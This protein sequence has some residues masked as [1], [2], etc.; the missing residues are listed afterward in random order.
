MIH[1]L[2]TSDEDRGGEATTCPLALVGR[3]KRL[4][5]GSRPGFFGS[6]SSRRFSPRFFSLGQDSAGC[7]FP[8]LSFLY[9]CLLERGGGAFLSE[10]LGQPGIFFFFSP[11][12]NNRTPLFLTCP[13][14]PSGGKRFLRHLTAPFPP[15]LTGPLRWAGLELVFLLRGFYLM[16]AS[17]TQQFRPTSS[18]PLLTKR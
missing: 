10:N 14:F 16:V 18:P 8:P 15:P 11:S 12:R 3:I 17:N 5:A 6:R 1:C 4:G 2:F 7:H 9:E 13:Y